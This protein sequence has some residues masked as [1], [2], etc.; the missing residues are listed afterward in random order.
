MNPGKL[1][2]L[3]NGIHHDLA[4]I[5][6]GIH[7]HL[8]R[9]LDELTYHH[10]MLLADVGGQ[11]QETLQLLLIRADIHGGTTQHVTRANQH[12]EAYLRHEAIDILHGRKLFPAGLIHADTIQHGGELLTVLGIIDALGGCPQDIHMLLVQT[13]RQ[14]IR[15]LA[16]G[17]DDHAVRVLQLEDIHHTLEGKLI[18]IKTIAHIIVGRHRLGIVVDHH[19][20]IALLTD[21]IQG[22][23]A[24][25]VELHRATDAVSAGTQHDNRAM[26]AQVRHVVFR[27]AIRQVQVIRLRRILGGQGIDLFHHRKNAMLLT[28]LANQHHT[29]LHIPVETDRPC[30]LEIREP[31]YLRPADQLRIDAPT[32]DPLHIE[33]VKLLGGLH[34]SI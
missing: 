5:G 22:L 19:G 7:L 2:M 33:S 30:D 27:T 32:L 21:R 10:R 6:H 15:D 3:A 23:H 18:E 28:E 26:I 34:D 9:M 29:L 12:G 1:D 17:G 8:F 20:T 25:P 31:L 11:F 13:H 16:A 24:T 14:V 4:M